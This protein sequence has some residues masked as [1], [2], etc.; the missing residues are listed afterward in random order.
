MHHLTFEEIAFFKTALE[1]T[2]HD[3]EKQVKNLETPPDMGDDVDEF[4]EEGEEAQ[5]FGVNLGTDELVKTRLQNVREAL[6][7]IEKGMYGICE[8]CGK[9]IG[10]DV[11]RVDP[12]SELCKTCKEQ[13]K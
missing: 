10:S 5:E 12:E 2:A 8:Q 4:E 7:K 11:L 1:R 3:L 9:T 6:Q 13:K